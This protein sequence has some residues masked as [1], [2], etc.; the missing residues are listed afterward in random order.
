MKRMPFIL[1]GAVIALFFAACQETPAEMIVVKKDTER[2]I[3]KAI[4]KRETDTGGTIRQRY[5]VVEALRYTNEYSE[6]FSVAVSAH[7]TVPEYGGMPL[8]RIAPADFS[9]QL[10]TQLFNGL[11][12]G[13]TMYDNSQSTREQLEEEILLIQQ[14]LEDPQYAEDAEMLS[15]Y[16]NL[17]SIA[18]QKWL[19]APDSQ[20]IPVCD[21]TLHFLTRYDQTNGKEMYTYYGCI[22]ADA[23]GETSF[24]VENNNSLTEAYVTK[25]ENDH[26]QGA[27]PVKKNATLRYET[28]TAQKNFATSPASCILD[29]GVVPPCAQ[30]IL[31]I[32]PN[33]AIEC[34][35]PLLSG[36]DMAVAS[37][38][39]ASAEDS[40]DY[41]Y[42]ICYTRKV[43]EVY[44]TFLGGLSTSDGGDS[45]A[46][47]WYYEELK[48]LINDSGI[49]R[50]EW[51]APL[52]VVET[53]T[54]SCQLM[55]FDE[56]QNIFDKM[57][58]IQYEELLIGKDKR[59]A[60]IDISNIKLE[61]NRIAEKNKIDS[62]LLI[63]VWN[64]YGK[65]V[66]INEDG[67]ETIRPGFYDDGR[68]EII[69]QINAIDGSVINLEKGY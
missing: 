5:D 11:C 59:K 55:G 37:V 53:I 61:L 16:R 35:A 7:I 29:Y 23:K 12:G 45:F 19:K 46:P 63:P 25:W 48:V 26:V 47:I 20:D 10:V 52:Q 9:Q 15:I 67:S 6:R 3:E 38:A 64:F 28:R 22:A 51:V 24:F 39:L 21:G 41:A 68:D 34:I 69:L 27:I 2:M 60:R 65:M 30:G 56:I 33:E 49:V 40:S 58:C 17:L 66:F 42:E 14:V 57:V 13:H 4:E 8:L 18:E 1:L 50:L 32:T 43:G 62:G 44:C 31:S 54:E 36:T